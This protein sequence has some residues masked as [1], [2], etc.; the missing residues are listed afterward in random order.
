ML[1][2]KALIGLTLVLA[3]VGAACGGDDDAV[4]T[5]S[6]PLATE[7]TV[8]TTTEAPDTTAAAA[9]TD[10]T[11]VALAYTSS[12]P[13]GFMAVGDITA[14]KD[15]I[16][17]SGAMLLDVREPTEYAEGHLEGAVNIP[18]RELAQNLDK[19][20]TDRQVFVYCKSGWRA[21]VGVS[22]LRLLGYDNVLGFPPSWNGWVE[23]GEPVTTDVP[24]AETFTVPEIA[25][26]LV[27]AIDDFLTT[28]PEGWLSAGDVDTVKQAI[29]AGAY[30]LDVR[31]TEE[32]AE[33]HIP[34]ATNFTLRELPTFI[35]QIPTD[36]TVISYCK[37]GWRAALSLPVLHLLGVDSA[38]GFPGSYAAWTAANEPV[39]TG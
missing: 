25:P 14:F 17:A 22:S 13:E 35:D 21:G 26:D 5:S 8:A 6:A 28:I 33:G 23:A 39:A 3:L 16:A 20:P 9:A 2:R 7:T 30:V 37:S 10:L 34:S 15:A 32:Y 4:D 31:T 29:D 38:R 36:V 27:A 11:Q 12:I 19:I 24:A 1:R 18:L